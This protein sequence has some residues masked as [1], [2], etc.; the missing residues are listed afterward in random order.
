MEKLKENEN[1]PK[2]LFNHF[3]NSLTN[4]KF[5]NKKIP[6]DYTNDGKMFFKDKITKQTGRSINNNIRIKYL[7]KGI[8]RVRYSNNRKLSNKLL[9]DDYKISKRM[10]NAIKFNKDIH[11]LSSDEKNIYYELQK[12]LNKEQDINVLI[13]SYLS[14]NHS[15]SLYNKINK[16]LYNK[17][18]NNLINK[19][20][21]ISLLNKINK[22]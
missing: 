7:D 9:K 3:N 22:S 19:K 5:K 17:L 15:K 11:K 8:L 18:K 2:S 1:V 13:G 12:F 4:L 6:V 10:V 21:Y 20:E 14:G 16:M